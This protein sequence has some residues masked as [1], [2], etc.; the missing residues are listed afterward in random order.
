MFDFRGRCSRRAYFG[1]IILQG[2][3]NSLMLNLLSSGFT[4]FFTVILLIAVTSATVR[5]LNDAGYSWRSFGWL[6]IPVVGFLAFTARIWSKSV[7]EL[8]EQ[9]KF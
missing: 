3:L 7:E 2:I 8:P 1:A 9:P 5:R 4:L 6:L